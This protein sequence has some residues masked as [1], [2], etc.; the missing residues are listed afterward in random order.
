MSET[1]SAA[2]GIIQ[3]FYSALARKDAESMVA[4]YHERVRFED[5]A[6]GVL[7]GERAKNMWR[8]LCESQ[9]DKAFIVTHSNIKS[10]QGAVTAHWEAKYFF[11]KKQRRVHN[12]IAARF[13]FEDGKI[14]NHLDV[15]DMKKWSVQALGIQGH[16]LGGTRF[17]QSKFQQ[18]TH[19]MLDAFERKRQS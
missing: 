17:F 12:K 16:L 5:P 11:G 8:M 9:Q 3:Q 15:F 7:N 1:F 14:I 4:F 10:D 19:A 18:R 13:A 6:F 2:E